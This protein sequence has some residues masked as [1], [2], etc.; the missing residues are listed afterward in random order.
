M[1]ILILVLNFLVADVQ[2]SDCVN[3]DLRIVGP[4]ATEGRVEI[5]IN[6]AW[7]AICDDTWTTTDANV[8][9]NQLGYYPSGII[10]HHLSLKLCACYS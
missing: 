9:C 10:M 5:C 2:F 7:G 8:A 1:Y 6:N 3:G 4:T